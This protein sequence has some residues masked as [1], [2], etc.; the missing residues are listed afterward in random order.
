M[1]FTLLAIAALNTA[2]SAQPEIAS[3][4]GQPSIVVVSGAQLIVE[5]RKPDGT[6]D[7][8]QPYTI[9][10]ADWSPASPCIDQS[11]RPAEFTKWY[12]RDVP[13][14]AGMRVNTIR[15]F[16]DFGIG[17]TATQILDELYENNVMV[18]MAV[19]RTIADGG[20][21]TPTVNA[22]KNHPAILM[23]A[24]GNEWD[25]NRYY[26][27]FTNTVQSA[28]FTEWAA[29]VIRGLDSNHPVA[30]ILGDIDRDATQP[31]LPLPWSPNTNST[32][33]IVNDLVPSVD[34]WGFNIYRGATFGGLFGQWQ[35]ISSKPMFLAEFGADSY[36]HRI[37][38]ESQQMQADFDERL[39]KEVYLHLS[40]EWPGKPA[41]G[42]LAFEWNDEWWK[43]G[44][45]CV[46]DAS[47]ESNPGQPDGYNDE[48]WFGIVD[49]DRQP[50][51]VYARMQKNFRA[52]RRITT[53]AHVTLSAFSEVFSQ[54]FYDG[55]GFCYKLG[56][57][58]GGRG[59][60]FAVVNPGTGAIED[61]RNF[62]TWYDKQAFVT[63]TDYISNSGAIPTGSIVLAAI[64]DE[65]GFIRYTPPESDCHEPLSD[66]RVEMGYQALER[67][68][69][70]QIRNVGYAGS[71]AMIAIQ[72]QGA[73]TEAYHDPVYNPPV[74]GFC[75]PGERAATQITVTVPISRV[76]PA[77]FEIFLPIVLRSEL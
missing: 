58:G 19:D 20:N 42:G 10:G 64:A 51:Q 75:Q 54:F 47:G 35:Q 6:L 70:T 32:H 46:H 5:R 25:L 72:G 73:L 49:I 2:A 57:G 16:W 45:L 15:T 66:P 29:Q 31:L 13:L 61:C 68:G 59:L 38:T 40:S 14:M 77:P 24:V 56:G 22:Y 48:E 41:L 52:D 17:P 63:M 18:I 4:P 26:G 65:A 43:N 74:N 11:Q 37:V 69:S 7:T 53:T 8:P 1:A 67:L 39:W 12:T 23:W 30:S 76:M 34:V 71:W 3:V 21:I 9:K 28:A 62:D 60:N 55:A 27:Q 36:D 33:K 50:K 44:N